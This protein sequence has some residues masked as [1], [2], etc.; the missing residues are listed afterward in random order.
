MKFVVVRIMAPKTPMTCFP[1]HVNVLNCM[2]EGF[3]N[4]TELLT[5]K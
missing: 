3:A 4:I 1:E 5:L 2:Q